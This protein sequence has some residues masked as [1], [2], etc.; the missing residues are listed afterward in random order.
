MDMDSNSARR[1]FCPGR[2]AG[3]S[4]LAPQPGPLTRVRGSRTRLIAA[5]RSAPVNQGMRRYMDDRW[6]WPDN[7]PI[8]EVLSCL[9]LMEDARYAGNSVRIGD[10]MVLSGAAGERTRRRTA[11][12][13]SPNREAALVQDFARRRDED[14]VPIGV[15]PDDDSVPFAV[16][17]R[18]GFNFYHFLTEALPQIALIAS[19]PGRAPVFVHLPDLQMLRSFPLAFIR[20]IY[21][22]LA[23]RIAFTSNHRR[24]RRVRAVLNHR[25]Y[26][27]QTRHPGLEPV[28]QTIDRA[29][30]WNRLDAG[31]E[32]RKFVYRNSFDTGMRLLRQDGLRRLDRKTSSDLPKR[33]WIGRDV[34]SGQARDR[35]NLG[36]AELLEALRTRG[37]ETLYMERLS[38]LEQ[39]AA[40]HGAEVIVAPHG[41]GLANMM[42]ARSAAEII[43]IGTRQTLKHRWGDFLGNAHVARCRYSTVFADVNGTPRD[44]TIPVTSMSEGL[45]GIDIGQPAVDAVLGRVDAA[46][47]RAERPVQTNAGAASGSSLG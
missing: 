3:I 16:D 6:R 26:L 25:H 31:R 34:S 13:G 45:R 23:P 7:L 19:H 27:Y 41:A 39:I 14:F 44:D 38:P 2:Q 10:R 46:I 21:P 12:D 35:A 32:S 36:E 37:F 20:A 24:Y 28:L 4:Y 40:W 17:M 42:F 18:N 22:E 15:A 11:E 29:D 1:F 43:E 8:C 47:A 30:P 33:I 5:S 9:V